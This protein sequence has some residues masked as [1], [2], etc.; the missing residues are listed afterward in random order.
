MN[1]TMPC[2]GIMFHHFHDDK[3]PKVQGS[4]SADT[5]AG[6]IDYLGPERILS[7]GEWLEKTRN[8]GLGENDI[9]ITFDDALRCQY[10]IAR[11]VLKEY[12]ITAF[13][14]VYSSV[15]EGKMER[16]EVHR[17]FRNVMFDD[18]DDFYDE[19]F[20]EL[21]NSS[22]GDE[23]AEKLADFRPEKYKSNFTFY[24]DNDRKFRY[25]RN[26]VLG[27]D[28]HQEIVESMIKKSDMDETG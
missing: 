28:R 3:H 24:T 13:W 11:P 23:A 12:G 5:F 18:I 2:H 22:Y 4:I 21:S 26:V 25:V 17:Y 27:H 14:F 15:F 8:G 7:A 19:F 10:D 1:V 9:C 16:M 6:M 20:K